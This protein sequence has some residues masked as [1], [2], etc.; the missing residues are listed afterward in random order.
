M[1]MYFIQVCHKLSN[2]LISLKSIIFKLCLY[3]SLYIFKQ[4]NGNILRFE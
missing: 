1:Y 3:M 4:Q 2:A